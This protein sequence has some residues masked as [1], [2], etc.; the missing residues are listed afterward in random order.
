ME[1][2]GQTEDNGKGKYIH[3]KRACKTWVTRMSV[4]QLSRHFVSI[5]KDADYTNDDMIIYLGPGVFVF[6]VAAGSEMEK[7]YIEQI[8][9]IVIAQG[10]GL[11]MN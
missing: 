8:S 10:N 4:S 7:V 2:I 5:G 9:N 6:D 1:F 3:L 11:R